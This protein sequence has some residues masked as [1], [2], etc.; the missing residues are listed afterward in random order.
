MR[1]S[2]G[3][4]RSATQQENRRKER[5]IFLSRENAASP[6]RDASRDGSVV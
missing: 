3:R 2:A 6:E 1:Q 4:R 5:T